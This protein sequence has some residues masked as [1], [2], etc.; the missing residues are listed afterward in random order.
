MRGLH[1]T[2]QRRRSCHPILVSCGQGSHAASNPRRT[3]AMVA[4]CEG[5]RDMAMS[6]GHVCDARAWLMRCSTEITPDH[7]SDRFEIFR[8]T[9]AHRA[10]LASARLFSSDGF[11][12]FIPGRFHFSA[13]TQGQMTALPTYAARETASR[14]KRAHTNT[15]LPRVF[16]P[17][18][19]A[20]V[21]A[22]NGDPAYCQRKQTAND[23]LGPETRARLCKCEPMELGSI[24]NLRK[25]E[26]VQ[27]GG[28]S[29][30]WIVGS[31]NI[32]GAILQRRY[33]FRWYC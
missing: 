6:C 12:V 29:S 15:C 23:G 3:S 30:A 17:G 25:T 20:C 27:V 4:R 26:Y 9:A 2:V 7:F 5:N 28:S 18:P 11:G 13:L 14:R 22:T 10:M 24:A 31:D 16:C 19:Q 8:R 1:C 21:L 32:T 33:T